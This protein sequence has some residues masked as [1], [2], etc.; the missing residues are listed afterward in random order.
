MGSLFR[1]DLEDINKE[2]GDILVKLE[3][4]SALAP[5]VR[6]FISDGYSESFS[7]LTEIFVKKGEFYRAQ[8]RK[9]SEK[10]PK[11]R[12]KRKVSEN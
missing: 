11:G 4:A 9:I 6:V 10:L 7:S 12:R 2:L 5:S 8:L 3:E 1:V